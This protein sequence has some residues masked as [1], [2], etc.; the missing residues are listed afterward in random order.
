M[1]K[2]ESF[3]IMK[4]SKINGACAKIEC[5]KEGRKEGKVQRYNHALKEQSVIKNNEEL[6]LVQ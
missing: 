3:G 1:N 4:E 5:N 2:E 6:I